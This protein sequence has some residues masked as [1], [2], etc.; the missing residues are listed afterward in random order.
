M[1]EKAGTEGKGQGR[2]LSRGRIAAAS[3]DRGEWVHN[4]T[5]GHRLR[6]GMG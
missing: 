2:A 6:L 5:A 3:V 4:S 1:E